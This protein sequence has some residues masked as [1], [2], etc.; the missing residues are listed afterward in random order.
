MKRLFISHLI[1]PSF[2]LMVS[3]PYPPSLL[4]QSIPTSSSRSYVHSSTSSFMVI[5]RDAMG[6]SLWPAALLSDGS[7]RAINFPGISQGQSR[8]PWPPP[9][10]VHVTLSTCPSSQAPS[11]S[12]VTVVTPFSC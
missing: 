5:G 3:S 2:T 10:V 6:P 1:E 11:N 4:T 8:D 7:P 9:E 12:I